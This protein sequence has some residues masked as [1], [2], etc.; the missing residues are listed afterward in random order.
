[1][2]TTMTEYPKANKV[3]SKD[4]KQTLELTPEVSKE[5]KDPLNDLMNQV[6]QAQNAYKSYLQA[7]RKVAAAY[8]E[9][10]RQGEKA[11]KEIEEQAA[12]ICAETIE[13]ASKAR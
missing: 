10:Q 1:M 11:Y 7:Q 13:K 12:N 2:T 4:E 3:V 5:G 6:N 9:R 8:Q